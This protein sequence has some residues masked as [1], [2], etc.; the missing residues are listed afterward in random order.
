MQ[1]QIS[2]L[3]SR[4]PE[5][6]VEG[7]SSPHTNSH[8]ASQITRLPAKD[9]PRLILQE[10]I[11]KVKVALT[12]ILTN[13][14]AIAESAPGI[15]IKVHISSSEP[16]RERHVNHNQPTDRRSTSLMNRSDRPLNFLQNMESFF[17]LCRKIFWSN[18]EEDQE[19]EQQ[20]K[21]CKDI[22]NLDIKKNFDANFNEEMQR[23]FRYATFILENTTK[24][25]LKMH[26]Y[27]KWTYLFVVATLLFSRVSS[28]P[29]DSKWKRYP[30][31][32]SLWT[33]SICSV[34]SA[35]YMIILSGE[36]S[37]EQA[38]C[39]RQLREGITNVQRK[40]DSHIN[41]TVGE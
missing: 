21:T 2:P 40:A 27:R 14:R 34:I 15:E 30:L 8:S 25:N 36:N 32:G 7:N 19:K 29:Y 11:H 38:N 31:T 3:P 37:S 9:S 10:R 16:V 20:L 13:L 4:V 24:Y 23:L 22:W 6:R 35:L 17:K 33:G 1:N 28:T 41:F 39:V 5:P 26:T 18:L 12:G